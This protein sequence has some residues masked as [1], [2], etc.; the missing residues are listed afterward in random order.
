VSPRPSRLAGL[1]R[2][3]VDEVTGGAARQGE[4][5]C[6]TRAAGPGRGPG[7]LRASGRSKPARRMTRRASRHAVTFSAAT[8]EPPQGPWR[9]GG[10]VGWA[11]CPKGERGAGGAKAI[12]DRGPASTLILAIV[13]FIAMRSRGKA[14]RKTLARLAPPT[15]AAVRLRWTVAPCLALD[16]SRSSRATRATSAWIVFPVCDLQRAAA[17]GAWR[18][19]QGRR[20]PTCAGTRTEA[21][22]DNASL[23]RPSTAVESRW[24]T[25]PFLTSGAKHDSATRRVAVRR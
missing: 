21:S 12:A 20:D 16:L 5:P 1:L 23:F 10:L 11:P 6:R 22:V 24:R 15:I 4:D 25:T 8:L 17:H 7:T 3:G 19:A 14:K 18:T 2:V 13:A 9:M